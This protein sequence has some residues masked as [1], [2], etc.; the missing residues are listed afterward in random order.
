MNEK[1]WSDF[2]FFNV[3]LADLNEMA[4]TEEFKWCMEKTLAA[5]NEKERHET[6]IAITCSLNKIS[7]ITFDALEKVDSE[8]E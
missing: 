3:Y 5:L 8:E 4:G 2:T 7:R 6:V 1:A